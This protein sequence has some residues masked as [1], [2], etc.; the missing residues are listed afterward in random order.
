M[1][2]SRD[3]GTRIVHNG[4][5]MR[6][7]HVMCTEDFALTTVR[8]SEQVSS[9]IPFHTLFYRSLKANRKA[10]LCMR[11]QSDSFCS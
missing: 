3:L 2:G 7:R 4:K 11:L 9:Y 6:K 8:E 10:I 5:Q 1:S